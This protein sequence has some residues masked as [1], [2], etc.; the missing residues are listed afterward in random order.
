MFLLLFLCAIGLVFR[1][2]YYPQSAYINSANALSGKLYAFSNYWAQYFSLKSQNEA[3]TE[4][5]RSLRDQVLQM[6]EQL[7][8][9]KGVDSLGFTTT[10]SLKYKVLKA[11][12]INNSLRC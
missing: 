2:N 3:L 11:N 8:Q 9:T 5:N 6:Q 1:S 10:D 4:E 7:R 12:V